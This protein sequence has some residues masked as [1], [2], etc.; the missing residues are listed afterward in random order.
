[1]TTT[2]LQ[3]TDLEVGLK[4]RDESGCWRVE[5]ACAQCISGY[6]FRNEERAIID[7]ALTLMDLMERCEL[8]WEWENFGVFGS[9]EWSKLRRLTFL[10]ENVYEAQGMYAMGV[11]ELRLIRGALMIT[12]ASGVDVGVDTEEVLELLRGLDRFNYHLDADHRG[13]GSV[14]LTMEVVD[15]LGEPEYFSIVELERAVRRSV[16]LRRQTLAEFEEWAFSEC[17]RLIGH[18]FIPK[19]PRQD[20]A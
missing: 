7:Y 13:N 5:P 8:A 9:S 20:K 12:L 10:T 6:G 14:G 15:R 2:D 1:M 3:S 19:R 17:D 4:Y 18:L 16:L 11:H